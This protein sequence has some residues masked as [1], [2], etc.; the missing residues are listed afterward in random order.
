VTSP[1]GAKSYLGRYFLSVGKPPYL[2]V[3]LFVIMGAGSVRPREPGPCP[4]AHPTPRRICTTGAVTVAAAVACSGQGQ[5]DLALP[6][7]KPG[8]EFCLSN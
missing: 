5:S 2:V 4:Y 6:L 8:A 3:A 1:G 7:S